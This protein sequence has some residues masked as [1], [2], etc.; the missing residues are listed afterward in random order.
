MYLFMYYERMMK[1]LIS[2]TVIMKWNARNKKR[3]VNLGYEFTKMNDEFEIDV[4]DLSD[5]SLT[6]VKVQCDYCGTEYEKSWYN[7]LLEIKKST[8]HTDCCCKCKKYKIVETAKNKYGVNSVF[9][10]DEVKEKIAQTNLEKYGSS[11]PFGSKSIQETIRRTNIERYGVASPLQNKQILQKV[12]DTCMERYGVDYYIRTQRYC[13][14]ESPVWKGGVAVE[15]NERATYD[16][17]NW[18]NK[19]FHRDNY[20]CQ[21]CG[22]RSHR[23]NPVKLNSHHI[24]N[25]KD[26]P[27]LRYELSNGIKLCDKCHFKFHSLY[28]KSFNNDVQLNEFLL[29]KGEKVC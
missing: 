26:Y 23:N 11:N 18:R 12:S 4:F 16:Y 24:Y 29:N 14:E 1:M 3:F 15:R 19:V 17:L 27:E 6:P 25:W 5:G 20:T 2:K 10:I 13:G 28:G 21:C 22:N 8:I 9:Q 7:Y